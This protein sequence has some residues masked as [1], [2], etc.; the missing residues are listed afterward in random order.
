MLIDFAGTGLTG[1]LFHTPAGTAFADFAVNG[2]RETWPILSNRLRAWLRRCEATGSAL[3]E[4]AILSK[5]DLLE[6]RALFDSPERA[7]HVRVAEHGGRIYLDLADGH[8]R[9]V[10][11]GLDGWQVIGAPPARFRRPAGMF[12]DPCA[13]ARRIGRSA[14][15]LPQPAKPQRR[16]VDYCLALGSAPVR[17][18]LSTVGDIR[19]AG[20]S[21]D[22]PVEAAQVL[23]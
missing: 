7:V 12:A 11:V 8:W 18:P 23:D 21:E 14:R 10:E 6:A 5:L 17:R 19:R 15:L 2:R 9:A 3:D 4:A 20:V 1:E 22:R 13:R 16:C